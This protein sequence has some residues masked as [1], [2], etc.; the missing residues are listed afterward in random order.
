MMLQFCY[1]G[2][3]KTMEENK[4]TVIRIN[5]ELL[6]KLKE[7]DLNINTAVTKLLQCN[8]DK[9]ITNK[10]QHKGFISSVEKLFITVENLK[11]SVSENSKDII[12]IQEVIQRLV[13]LNK[14]RKY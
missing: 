6:N 9:E 8:I 14:L 5:T 7:I 13:T 10:L 1:K 11:N 12:Q 2:G 3:Y 4:T